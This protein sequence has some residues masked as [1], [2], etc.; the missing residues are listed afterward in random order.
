MAVIDNAEVRT[1]AYQAFAVVP[2]A[3]DLESFGQASWAGGKFLEE[4]LFRCC[5]SGVA[6]SAGNCRAALG[7]TAEGGCPYVA[8]GGRP[9]PDYSS[10]LRHLLDAS[11]RFQRPKQNASG[12]SVGQAGHIQAVVIAVDEVDVG[13]TGGTEENGVARRQARRRVRCRIAF[14]EIRFGFDDATG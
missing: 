7:W 14:A 3:R 12:D 9:S 13:V 10:R 11:H 6:V 8:G 4:G 2:L 5:K 1:R